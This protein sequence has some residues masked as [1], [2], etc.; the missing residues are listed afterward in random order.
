MDSPT[1]S[2]T[3]KLKKAWRAIGVILTESHLRTFLNLPPWLQSELAAKASEET[4]ADNLNTL[5]ESTG[6]GTSFPAEL[7]S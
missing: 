5:S 7:H 2:P 6:K 4:T 1:N 3:E